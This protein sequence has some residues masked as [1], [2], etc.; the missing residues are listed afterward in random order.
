MSDKHP[1]RLKYINGIPYL[2]GQH[3]QLDQPRPS[4]SERL[5]LAWQRLF[6]PRLAGPALVF[7]I[8]LLVAGVG[9]LIDYLLIVMPRNGQ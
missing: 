9:G 8:V 7:V 2:T 3:V 1:G 4:R 5:L 6:G